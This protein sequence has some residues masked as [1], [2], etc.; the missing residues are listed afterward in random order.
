MENEVERRPKSNTGRWALAVVSG[1]VV[2]CLLSC[3]VC[4]AAQPT[5]QQWPMGFGYTMTFCFVSMGPPKPQMG[6]KWVSPFISSALPPFGAVTSACYTT[7]YLPFL[8]QRG[9]LLYP[10]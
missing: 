7:P 5:I 2:V 3:V 10:P 8:P 9:E 4:V 1:V 6:V